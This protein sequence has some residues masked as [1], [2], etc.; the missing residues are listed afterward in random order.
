MSTLTG[1][2]DVTAYGGSHPTRSEGGAGIGG[3]RSYD[4]DS[5]FESITISGQAKVLTHGGKNAQSLGV[6]TFYGGDSPNKL[7]IDT[8]KTT[9]VLVNQD[10]SVGAFWGDG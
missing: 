7:I 9:L 3:G 6:G 5:G 2:A 1:T 10:E 4:Y 8:T